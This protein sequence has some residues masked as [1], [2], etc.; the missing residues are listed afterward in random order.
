MAKIETRFD[1]ANNQYVPILQE[2]ASG[3]VLELESLID[4]AGVLT[5]ALISERGH[6]INIAFDSYVAF[7]KL[8]EGDAMQTL[9]CVSESSALGK[10]FYEVHNSEFLAW[11]HQQSHSVRKSSNIRHFAILATD[12]VID[13]LAL[14]EPR[15]T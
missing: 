7:R 6:R 2:V 5:L 15:L 3:N 11:Y 13:V 9:S 10:C 4:Q 1:M 8:D 12:D 14:G